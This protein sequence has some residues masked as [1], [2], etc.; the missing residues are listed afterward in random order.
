MELGVTCKSKRPADADGT[1]AFL[2]ARDLQTLVELVWLA[3]A[4]SAGVVGETAARS[5][6]S[7]CKLGQVL[8]GQQSESSLLGRLNRS[9]ANGQNVGGI[10]CESQK[11]RQDI[12]STMQMCTHH[13]TFCHVR[14]ERDSRRLKTV[15]FF[16]CCGDF[17]VITT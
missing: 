8:L 15:I 9:C 1:G 5:I 17:M 4:R 14:H 6:L 10:V 2:Q 13:A 3:G 16:E 7:V 11:C 12:T